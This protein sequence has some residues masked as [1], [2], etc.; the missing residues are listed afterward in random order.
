MSK[1]LEAAV[2]RAKEI[3]W[4]RFTDADVREIIRAFAENLT[5]D[6]FKSD[7]GRDLI[8]GAEGMIWNEGPAAFTRAAIL[9]GLK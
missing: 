9:E 3:G 8:D 4:S 5:D 7:E 2:E 6:D 1:A